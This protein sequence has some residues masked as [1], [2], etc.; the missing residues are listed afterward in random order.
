M[1]AQPAMETSKSFWAEIDGQRMHYLKA[2]SGSPV[3]LVHGL[4]GGS[5]CWRLNTIRLAEQHTLFALDLPGQGLSDAKRGTNCGMQMQ[6]QRLAQFIQDKGFR[7]VDLVASSWGGAIA[8]LLAAGCS[9]V[10]SLALAAPVNPWSTFG[11]ERVRFCASTM[12]SLLVHCG[13][14]FSGRFHRV[15]L[16]Q[17]YGDTSRI[18]PGTLEGYSA[19]IRR[20]GRA[21]SLINIF[22]NWEHDMAAL[23][24]AIPRVKAPTLLI[25]GARDG[26]VDLRSAEPL[27]ESLRHCRLEVI[28]GAGHLPFEEC[29]EVFN[30]LVLDF[31]ERPE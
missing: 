30:R 6:A 13:L 18:P 8:L 14:P 12:G 1:V 11:M 26:A 21:R 2:G 28:P 9:A 19:L 22:R 27:K 25:W 20:R 7:S 17:M 10:R 5:F 4:L 23:E 24:E 16:E 31:I 15:A 3:M 29:P